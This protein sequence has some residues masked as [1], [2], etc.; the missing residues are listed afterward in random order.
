[1][2]VKKKFEKPELKVV[3]LKQAVLAPPPCSSHC[4]YDCD[5]YD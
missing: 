4:D 3:E 5:D 1:M 2:E